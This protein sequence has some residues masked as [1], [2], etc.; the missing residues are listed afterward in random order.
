MKLLPWS[1]IFQK[2]EL[3]FSKNSE[4]TRFYYQILN[5]NLVS[6]TTNTYIF[7]QHA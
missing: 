6:K 5:V 3:S 2:Q 7:L 1:K 4:R